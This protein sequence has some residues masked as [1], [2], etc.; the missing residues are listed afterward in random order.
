MAGKN[1]EKKG[2]G[3]HYK[4]FW[5]VLGFFKNRILYLQVL[6]FLKT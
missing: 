6:T 5:R 4:G 1:E 2:V 3:L